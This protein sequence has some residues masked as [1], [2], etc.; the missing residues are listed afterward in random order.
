MAFGLFDPRPHVDGG[1][2]IAGLTPQCKRL[3]RVRRCHTNT[4]SAGIA[5]QDPILRQLIDV[6][7]ASQG[8]HRFFDASIHL[9]STMARACG[10]T[11]L[12]ELCAN[13][14]TT[15]KRDVAYLTGVSYGGVV[16]L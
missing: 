6:E 9:M 12:S 7:Q 3:Y 2:Q 15:W 10:H 14:L 4:C 11:S 5:T 8:L 16:P 13:D 1:I